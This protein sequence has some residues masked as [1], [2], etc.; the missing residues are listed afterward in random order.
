MLAHENPARS[1]PRSI[2]HMI[3]VMTHKFRAFFTQWLV[4]MVTAECYGPT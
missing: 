2:L 3:N 4:A 1:P